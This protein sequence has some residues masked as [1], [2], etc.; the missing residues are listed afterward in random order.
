[1]QRAGVVAHPVWVTPFDAAERWPSGDF[2]NQS[3]QDAGLP[4]WTKAGRS[5]E[6]TDVVLWHVFGLHHVP[7]VE[8]WPVMPVEIHQVNLRPADF[9][10]GNPALD[11]P[12]GRDAG[13]R[14]VGRQEEQELQKV[15]CCG[16]ESSRL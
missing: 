11:V 7:R 2:C 10:G 16:V 5:T 3:S 8:D 4:E 6:A 14:E 15:G 9:F 12:S 13:S 1:M